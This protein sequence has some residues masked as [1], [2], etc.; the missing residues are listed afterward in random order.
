M[1]SSSHMLKN[2]VLWGTFTKTT[3]IS[4]YTLIWHHKGNNVYYNKHPL[5]QSYSY[6][7]TLNSTAKLSKTKQLYVRLHPQPPLYISKRNGQ[8]IISIHLHLLNYHIINHKRM[9][10]CAT[11]YFP[12]I[13]INLWMSPFCLKST[14]YNQV[15]H[16]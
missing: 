1:E 2:F 5:H 10:S 14:S 16:P 11:Y 9:K 6:I 7:L 15:K 13:R 3:W 8:I 12:T 4:W